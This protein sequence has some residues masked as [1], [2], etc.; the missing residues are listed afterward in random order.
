MALIFHAETFDIISS[1]FRLLQLIKIKHAL[2]SVQDTGYKFY[3][4]S[5]YTI[6]YP[7]SYT[8]QSACLIFINCNKRETLDIISNVSA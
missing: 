2:C 6:F 8:E 5:E 1:V 7:V 3:L 4:K